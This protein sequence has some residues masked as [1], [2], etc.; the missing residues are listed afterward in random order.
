MS[1]GKKI[2]VPPLSPT[3]PERNPGHGHQIVADMWGRITNNSSV[4]LDNLLTGHS[5]F[6]HIYT[7]FTQSDTNFTIAGLRT[8]A[9]DSG[10][11]L[12]VLPTSL[13]HTNYLSHINLGLL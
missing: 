2:F 11:G 10:S 8:P 5:S 12:Q 7:L 13:I 4:R 6:I 1:H 9:S 3:L